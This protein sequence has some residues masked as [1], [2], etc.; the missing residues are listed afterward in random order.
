[1][2]TQLLKGNMGRHAEGA[3]GGVMHLVYRIEQ[4]N[5]EGRET[6]LIWFVMKID[7]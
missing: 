4:G 2:E 5:Q 6:N 1:M 7:I 3:G